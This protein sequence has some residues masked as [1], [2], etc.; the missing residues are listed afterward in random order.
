[1]NEMLKVGERFLTMSRVFNVQAGLSKQ[2][3][4]LPKR[5]FIPFASGPSKDKAPKESDFTQALD[6]FYGMI[7]WDN[8]G[9]PTP[10]KLEELGVGWVKV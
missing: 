10:V 8:N 4:V 3:D 6:N 7:G 9:K 1:M 2:D 5:F